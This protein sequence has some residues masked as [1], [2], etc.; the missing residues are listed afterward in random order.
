ME[1]GSFTPTVATSYPFDNAFRISD[2]YDIVT[3]YEMFGRFSHVR[4][5]SAALSDPYTVNFNRY[6]DFQNNPYLLKY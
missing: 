6:F 2:A 5:Y 4:V 1:K 3:G